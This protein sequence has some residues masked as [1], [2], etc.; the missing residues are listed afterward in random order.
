MKTLTIITGA[1]HNGKSLLGNRLA[2]G[3]GGTYKR[4]ILSRSNLVRLHKN[5]FTESVVIFEQV[6]G[7]E[8][9]QLIQDIDFYKLIQ[10]KDVIIITS[11]YLT[12]A[13]L[14]IEGSLGANFLIQIVLSS[15][16]LPGTK[17]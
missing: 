2:K 1:V 11:T 3:M 5:D 16:I 6:P 12:T 8:I 7:Y 15:L 10:K 13:N 17:P 9:I 14:F 4:E